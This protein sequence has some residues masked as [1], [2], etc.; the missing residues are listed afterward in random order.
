MNNKN[1][2]S[3][4]KAIPDGFHTVTPF[5]KADDCRELMTF[6][7]NAFGGEIVQ[8]M[9]HDDGKIMHATLKIGDSLI[10]VSDPMPGMPHMPSVLYLYV[11]DMDA[12]YQ[13]AL[14]AK[15]E[16]L[17]EPTDEFYGDRSAGVKDK[18]GNQWW[19]ATHIEDVSEEEL[20]KRKEEFMATAK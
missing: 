15:A 2:K 12:V 4:V 18:W 6:V 3:N 16:S 1:Q 14:K 7:Q 10:M 5:V 20:E 13:K 19:I 11:E 9:E 17:R 8:L